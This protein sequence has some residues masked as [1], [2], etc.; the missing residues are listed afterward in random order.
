MWRS[1]S[2]EKTLMLE[3]IEGRRRRGIPRMRW[4]DGITDSTDMNLSKLREIVKPSVLQSMG[5]QRVWHYLGTEQQQGQQCL[6][7]QVKFP[8]TAHYTATQRAG[9]PNTGEGKTLHSGQLA[10]GAEQSAWRQTHSKG[11]THTL[12]RIRSEKEQGFP[13]KYS[14][15]DFK[16]TSIS[17]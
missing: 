6:W 16:Y 12:Q 7:L 17:K 8:Q 2:F 11:Q 3:K 1:D 13:S 15:Y 10:E 9:A 5:S 4:L 14:L